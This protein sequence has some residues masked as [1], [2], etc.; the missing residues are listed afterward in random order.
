MELAVKTDLK[1]GLVFWVGPEW[2]FG[3]HRVEARDLGHL[4]EVGQGPACV[5][6]SVPLQ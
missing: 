3:P 5:H 1:A 4:N 6:L 2:D